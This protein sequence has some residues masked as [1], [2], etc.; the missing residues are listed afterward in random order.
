MVAKFGVLSSFDGSNLTVK[1]K[2]EV[3]TQNCFLMV[4]SDVHGELWCIVDG[5]TFKQYTTS[6]SLGEGT[7]SAQGT[8]GVFLA[9]Y[10]GSDFT[11]FGM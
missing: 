8:F 4:T 6:L 11:T 1:T 10:G 2:S 7:H 9:L 5:S 3:S